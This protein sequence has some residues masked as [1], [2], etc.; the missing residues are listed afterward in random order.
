[1]AGERK[2]EI[3]QAAIEIIADEGYGSLSMRALARA[4]GMKL[5]A[6]QYHF[7]TWEDLLS[8]LAKYIADTYQQSFETLQSE[9]EPE[10]L[11]LRD[12]VKFILDDVPGS[13]LHADRLF[14]QLWAMAQV[15]PVMESLLDDIY[16]EYLRKLENGLINMGSATPRAEALALMSLMEGSTLFVGSNRRWTNQA[17]AV[18]DATFAF[19]DARYG[20][21]D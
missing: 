17:S 21:A 14:P 7:R 1:M 12:T 19:L 11:S 18:R 2:Q 8:A 10:A 3:L 9:A 15:E 5:G 4:S 6:L 16:V 20:E 13:T